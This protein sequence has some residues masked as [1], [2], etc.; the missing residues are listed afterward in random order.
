MANGV[1][2]RVWNQ[3]TR[4]RTDRYAA[5]PQ[6]MTPRTA[7]PWMCA[8]GRAEQRGNLEYAGRQDDRGGQQEGEAG[9][10]FVVQAAPQPAGHGDPGPADPREQREDLRRP[11]Q[12]AGRVGEPRDTGVRPLRAAGMP[13]NAGVRGVAR[14]PGD[15]RTVLRGRRPSGQR[16]RR[17]RRRRR[18][19][20]PPAPPH[21]G[22]GPASRGCRRDPCRSPRRGRNHRGAAHPAPHRPTAPADSDT[23]GHQFRRRDCHHRPCSRRPSR[24][25]ADHHPLP[26]SPLRPQLVNDPC[27]QRPILSRTSRRRQLPPPAEASGQDAHRRGG[28]DRGGGDCD[29]DRRAAA[30]AGGP[31][32]A[33]ALGDPRPVSPRAWP[34]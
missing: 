19:G 15:G 23:A 3:R 8:A 9:R 18:G 33:A 1:R 16:S 17:S 27:R 22:R 20:P 6:T 28:R 5:I 32:R 2:V 11:D 30:S 10:V 21:P 7:W 14:G 24:H 34:T 25:L 13:R 29:G 31:G 4:N 12:R 26:A